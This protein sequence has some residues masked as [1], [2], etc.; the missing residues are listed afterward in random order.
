[1]DQSYQGAAI[2]TVQVMD[3]VSPTSLLTTENTVR[4]SI[5]PAEA[6]LKMPASVIAVKDAGVPAGNV[7]T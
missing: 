1:M 5:V 2:V 6:A 7:A 3:M 4:Q